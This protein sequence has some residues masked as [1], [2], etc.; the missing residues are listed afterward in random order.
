MDTAV[1]H[2][3][4]SSSSAHSSL[5]NS[6]ELLKSSSDIAD[7][8]NIILSIDSHMSEFSTFINKFDTTVVQKGINV[9]SE[10]NGNISKACF[11]YSPP[12]HSFVHLPFF[13]LYYLIFFFSLSINVF[14]LV[15][16]PL[17]LLL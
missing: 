10:Y 16:S 7:L 1:S 8:S 3:F 2:A 6:V 13:Y 14:S 12:L 11:F 5:S 4:L 17:F 9:I 15:M